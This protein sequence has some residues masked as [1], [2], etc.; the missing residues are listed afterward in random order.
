MSTT[1]KNKTV[2]GGRYALVERVAE[3]GMAVVWKAEARGAAGFSRPVAIKEIKVE[4]RAIQKYI[5]MFIEEAR[6][7]TELAHP[8]IVQVV[9]FVIEDDTYYLVL[10]WVE[11]VDL[12]GFTRAFCYLNQPVPWP[13][14]VA[15]AVGALQGL[16][17]AHQRCRADGAVSPVIHRDV[18]P[19]NIMLGL[20]G[21]VKLSDFGLARARD[22]AMTMTAPGMVKGKLGYLAP[23]IASGLGASV[24]SDQFS[25]GAVLW[26]AL[27]GERLF[28][29]ESDVEVFTMIRTGQIKPLASVRPDIPK[30]VVDAV[31]K[32]LALDPTDRF[33]S[34]HRFAAELH[35]CLRTLGDGIFDAHERLAAAVKCARET[36]TTFE[37]DEARISASDMNQQTWSLQIDVDSASFKGTTKAMT[38]VAD[39]EKG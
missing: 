19:H 18:S 21:T 35:E 39:P 11:G 30:R 10:E 15:V 38:V 37:G 3:G 13:L 2:V 14:S 8:N 34:T 17:A 20:S 29:A 4:Y 6:I 26:E 24:A 32:S 16:S 33:P 25:M 31:H 28:D 5:Q 7:G 23:E 27:A 36:L 22:R 12:Y 9:D 1:E